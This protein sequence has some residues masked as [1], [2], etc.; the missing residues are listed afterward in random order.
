MTVRRVVIILRLLIYIL[1]QYLCT[2]VETQL[3]FTAKLLVLGWQ[4]LNVS[5]YV[6]R[7]SQ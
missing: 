3:G 1:H 6:G 7:P 5:H 2:L 4:S